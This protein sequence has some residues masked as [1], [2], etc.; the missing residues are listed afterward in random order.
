MC[1]IYRN[2]T[3]PIPTAVHPHCLLSCRS[4]CSCCSPVPP[5]PVS[6]TSASHTRLLHYKHG[7]RGWTVS[8]IP[9]K[10]R[11]W[12]SPQHSLCLLPAWLTLQLWI[13]TQYISVKHRHLADHTKTVQFTVPLWEPQ[14]QL[15]KLLP[16]FAVF[17]RVLLLPSCFIWIWSS[18][19]C[20][21]NKRLYFRPVQNSM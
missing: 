10:V 11:M 2:V 4:S 3:F 17:S 9:D 20:S 21:Q 19:T 12:D 7:C 5:W 6:P 18:A 16:H 8:S 13:W 1:S 14:V 15:K